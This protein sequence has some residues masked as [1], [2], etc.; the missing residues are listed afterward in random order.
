MTLG[1]G[2]LAYGLAAGALA[3][4]AAVFAFIAM[5]RRRSERPFLALGLFALA[6]TASTVVTV[7]LQKSNSIEEYADLL[8]LFGMVNLLTL[9]AMVGLVAAWTRA[10]PRPIIVAFLGASAMIAVLQVVL[11]EGLLAMEI[12]GLREVRLFGEPFVVHEASSSPWR[13]ALDVYLLA[14]LVLIGAALWQSLRR[15]PRAEAIVLAVGFTMFIGVAMYDSLVD[16]GVIDTPYLA[17]FGAV[18]VVGVAAWHLAR[19][20]ASTERRLAS[21]TSELEATVIDRTAALIES[22]RR[23]ERQLAQQRESARLLAT[24]AEQ[25]ES[26]NALALRNNDLDEIHDELLHVLANL[27]GLLGVDAVGLYIDGTEPAATLPADVRWN[28]GRADA[29]DRDGDGPEANVEP[30]VMGSRT[31]GELVVHPAE[32]RALGEDERRYIELT[33]DHLA[34][35]LDRLELSDRIAATAVDVERHRIAR[36]LHDSVTQKLYSIAFLADAV[37]RQL[38]LGTERV[39][40]TIRRMRELLLA[41]LAELRTLLFELQPS[42]SNDPS[43]A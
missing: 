22:N 4:T 29:H 41:S 33:A 38:D 7:R 18:L 6:M 40:E 17:P 12:T 23:L 21:Q 35:F 25:F 3:A 32:G 36:E 26:V 28:A 8:K 27:G 11:P 14:T 5:Q 2:T 30:L 43:V 37:P 9:V 31:L 1:L 39:G 34:G 15:G 10:V 42:V 24:L 19:R 16:E 13:P 20:V